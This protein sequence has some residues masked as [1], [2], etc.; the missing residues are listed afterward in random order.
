ME[1]LVDRLGGN[2]LAQT[3]LQGL[4]G[5]V[6]ADDDRSPDIVPHLLHGRVVDVVQVVA[7]NED[8]GAGDL[9]GHQLALAHRD[10]AK[11]AALGIVHGDA[12]VH[13]DGTARLHEL[14]LT[15]GLANTVKLVEL[16]SLGLDVLPLELLLEGLQEHLLGSLNLCHCDHS[17]FGMKPYFVR[18]EWMR[19]TYSMY[20]VSSR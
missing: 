9:V 15:R 14:H 12:A 11:V 6:H 10:T 4:V 2:L 16:G 13:L 3:L 1:V 5:K 8:A 17:S 18:S 20:S 7:F 19:W